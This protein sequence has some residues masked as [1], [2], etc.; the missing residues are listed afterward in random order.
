MR[1][2]PGIREAEWRN[3]M[4]EN[5]EQSPRQR[6]FKLERLATRLAIIGAGFIWFGAIALICAVVWGLSK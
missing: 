3:E 5:P 2:T 4:R 6:R 1:L